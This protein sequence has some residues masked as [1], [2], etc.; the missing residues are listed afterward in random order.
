MIAGRAISFLV[1]TLLSAGC[2]DSRGRARKALQRADAEQLRTDV[3]SYYK[4][5]FAE[6]RKTIVIVGEQSW[7][8]SFSK[9]H[10]KRVTA[11]PDGFAFCLESSGNEES[12]L[13]IVPL[14]M[15]HDPTPTPWAS[16]EKLSEGIFWYS[17]KP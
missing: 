15:D 10:P 6:H 2:S 9:L 11:Y 13:Y 5:L 8:Q 3:A 14:G 16:F 7:A 4:N 1:F 12:G 17:F